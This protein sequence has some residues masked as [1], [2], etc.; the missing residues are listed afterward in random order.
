MGLII[1]IAVLYALIHAWHAR[2]R[3]KRARHYPWWRRIWVSAPGPF[4][5]RISK[6]L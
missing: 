5:T 4:G 2:K 3:W 1:L 6:R